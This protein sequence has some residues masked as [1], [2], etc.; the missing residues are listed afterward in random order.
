[1]KQANCEDVLIAAMAL[2]DGE[3]ETGL[4]SAQVEAHV[5]QC[6]TC[7]LETAQV[8]RTVHLLETRERRVYNAD[9]W[10]A[11]EQR[12]SKKAMPSALVLWALGIALIAYKLFELLPEEAPGY[13]FRIVPVIV[14]AA[15]FIFIKENPFKIKTEL[16]LEK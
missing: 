15:A 5:A 2:A 13:V 1:M 11:I 12:L 4:S 10:P 6:E 16:I 8:S 14:I 3:E 9:L 7:R